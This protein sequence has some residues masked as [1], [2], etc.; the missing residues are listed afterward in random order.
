MDLKKI[1]IS[2][3]LCVL[4]LSVYGYPKYYRW[5]NRWSQDMNFSWIIDQVKLKMKSGDKIVSIG[6]NQSLAL[7]FPEGI[8]V[9]DNPWDHQRYSDGKGGFKLTW[10]RPET[11][12]E[13]LKILV[14]SLQKSNRNAILVIFGR[15]PSRWNDDLYYSPKTVQYIHD[16]F[17]LELIA[18][19]KELKAYRIKL[20]VEKEGIYGFEKK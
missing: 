8:T 4:L 17:V 6:N 20:A 10:W 7:H 15:T 12:Q 11:Y 1:I 9:W 13:K 5:V 16:N 19:A 3:L 18:S 2:I 14:A